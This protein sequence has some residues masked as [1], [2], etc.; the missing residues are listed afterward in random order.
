MPTSL[1][2][3]TLQLVLVLKKRILH[4]AY[5][6]ALPEPR[7][8]LEDAS[9][10]KETGEP[11]KTVPEVDAQVRVPIEAAANQACMHI[12]VN[13]AWKVGPEEDAQVQVQVQK[14]LKGKMK[15]IATTGDWNCF[16]AAL[17]LL[18]M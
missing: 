13:D 7:T 4:K 1:Q 15:V 5:K 17:P 11:G 2:K 18:C 16:S 3:I 6:D 14:P 8:N 9:V 12:Q 10:R